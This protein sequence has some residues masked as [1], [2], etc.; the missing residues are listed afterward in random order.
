MISKSWVKIVGVCLALA[1]YWGCDR[2]A[3]SIQSD[4]REELFP[5]DAAVKESLEVEGDTRQEDMVTNHLSTDVISSYCEPWAQWHCKRVLACGCVTPGGEAP[6]F[7]SCLVQAVEE[8]AN[9]TENLQGMAEAGLLVVVEQ[10]VRDCIAEMERLLEPCEAPD[11]DR[12]TPTC[13]R[14][15]SSLAPLG[16]ACDQGPCAL[17]EGACRLGK[18][19]PLSE[20]GGPCEERLHC[21]SGD[22]VGGVCR[23]FGQEGEK[24]GEGFAACLEPLVC[25]GGRCVKPAPVGGSCETDG[26]CEVGLVCEHGTCIEFHDEFCVIG[27]PCGRQ[28]VCLGKVEPTCVPLGGAGDSCEG[29]T[30]CKES[31]W[32]QEGKCVEAPGLDEPCGDGIYC[33]KG[34]SCRFEGPKAGTCGPLPGLGEPCGLDIRGPFVCGPGLACSGGI[35]KDPPQEGEPCADL[36]ICA[37]EDMD[38]DGLAPDLGCDFTPQGSLCVRKRDE[39]GNCQNDQVCKP[40]LYCDFQKG[41][42]TKTLPLGSP[43]RDSHECG[44]GATCIPDEGLNLRCRP[45]PKVGER[46]LSECEP[47]AF[48]KATIS[49]LACR[50]LLCQILFELH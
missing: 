1:C 22:C 48:C 31:L 44:A 19:L 3:Q 49:D 13:L 24:C 14:Q 32:C 30:G 36:A 27:V 45:L 34:L 43:C 33:A 21:L 42:C 28:S 15:F 18:C 26:G 23:S 10:N 5:Q 6:S 50:P 2:G 40:G 9:N 12:L 11:S 35:C 20:E 4:G 46:C 41:Q 37:E 47:S 39:G 8:C 29:S 38:G 16:G 25:Q 7:N 17:G